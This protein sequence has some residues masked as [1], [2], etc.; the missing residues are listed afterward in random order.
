MIFVGGALSSG[1]T[2]TRVILDSHSEIACGPES[3][4]VR[5]L[6]EHNKH[7]CESLAIVPDYGL[8]EKHVNF[9]YRRLIETL[10]KRYYQHSGKARFAEKTP[11]NI[12]C[13]KQ[14]NRIFPKSPL[15]HV[16]RDGRDV[17]CSVIQNGVHKLPKNM[18]DRK[19][20]D[21]QV[22]LC[23]TIS[24]WIQYVMAGI[25]AARD[26][27]VK[28]RYY[29]IRY[30]DIILQP[31]PTL[32]KL[33]DFL[34]E[35]WEPQ[36]L[37]FYKKERNEKAKE[38]SSEQVTKDIFTSSLGRWKTE[39]SDVDIFT[40]KYIAGEVLMKLGYTKDLDW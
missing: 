4:F 30:E 19:N 21:V 25:A 38:A 9:A 40:F 6:A 5:A 28:D 20:K 37:D 36:V 26:P 10:L 34:E 15:I 35:R 32:R 29:E 12:L 13:F 2:L 16:I 17:L 24:N 27:Q 11:S 3:N 22:A 31:E 23:T 18:E 14:I 39:L 1:T 33:F 8:D 7:M